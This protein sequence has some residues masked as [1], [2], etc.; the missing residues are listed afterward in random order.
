MSSLFADAKRTVVL[1]LP[2][3]I[4]QVATVAT[5]FVDTVMAG[6]LNALA[7]AS[8]SIASAIWSAGLM[9]IIGVSMSVS[10]SVSQLHGA[11]KEH[12]TGAL[13]R[14]AFYLGMALAMLYALYLTSASPIIKWMGI[15]ESIR[16]QAEGYLAGI[17]WGTP[18]L[19]GFFILRFFCEG[20][21]ITKTTMYFGF[22]ALICNIPAN[23]IFMYGKLGLPAMGA[24]GIGYATALVEWIQ[25]IGLLWYVWKQPAFKKAGLFERFDWPDFKI[26]RQLLK[27][28]LPIGVSI[29]VEGSLFVAVSLLMGK[30]GAMTVAAH[31]IAINF[32]SLV[33][34]IP[35]GLGMALTVRVGNAVG[36]RD[37]LAVKR[38]GIVGIGL[39]LAT[40]MVSALAMLFFPG[41][42]AGI[43][44]DDQIVIAQVLELLFLAAIFQLPDGLQ[45]AAAG[46][47]RGL[48]DT[49]I[50]MIYTVVAY[51]LVGMPLGYWLGFNAEMGARGMWMGLIAGL[52][53]AAVLLVWRFKHL[54]QAFQ[55]N[56]HQTDL[57]AQ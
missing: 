56:T 15:E 8:V 31:Q 25:F 43:Y 33:F 32:S 19:A 55:A 42:I 24:P 39:V 30:L 5:G 7:L 36:R 44:T 16:P 13:V 54:S 11:G 45:V 57:S 2:V 49:K 40:Q 35:M 12:E 23:Y 20:L 46:A 4:G 3:I 48:K 34:M 14:Q 47:L 10:A 38:V 17:I 22:V 41:Q 28:G 51:W 50:P 53:V 52:T 29:F 9:F 26:I 37:S 18:A 21:S 1:A 6:Q 27:T